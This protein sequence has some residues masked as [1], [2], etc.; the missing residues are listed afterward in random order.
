MRRLLCLPVLVHADCLTSH[1]RNH[2]TDRTTI[3]VLPP[4]RHAGLRTQLAH[5][6]ARHQARPDLRS[7]RLVH[8]RRNDRDPIV[9]RRRVREDDQLSIR[10]LDDD[11]LLV[12]QRL[13][14]SPARPRNGVGRRG[15]GAHGERSDTTAPFLEE[16][17]SHSNE[18]GGRLSKF[19]HPGTTVGGA[20]C[21]NGKLTRTLRPRNGNG[22]N[23][24]LLNR[25]VAGLGRRECEDYWSQSCGARPRGRRPYKS[26]ETE[27]AAAVTSDVSRDPL[28]LIW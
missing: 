25:M 12:L 15:E 11:S 28:T 23:L 16:V 5:P 13:Q 26:A 27:K 17:Q 4:D 14:P 10:E 1:A 3:V 20:G 22:K 7:N 9:A 18:A 8:L 21:S 19:S 2:Q 6:L 24:R